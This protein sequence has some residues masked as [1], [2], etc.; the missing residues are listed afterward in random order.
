MAVVAI[1]IDPEL[2]ERVA[3]RVR[4]GAY[5]DLEQF[6]DLAGDDIRLDGVREDWDDLHVLRL[7]AAPG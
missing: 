6:F 5:V 7:S 1:N 2:Y 4:E 3:S